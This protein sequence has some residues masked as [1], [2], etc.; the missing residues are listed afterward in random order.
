MWIFRWII[1]LLIVFV[2]VMFFAQNSNEVVT[3]NLMNK[4]PEMP[5][6]L[7]LF[8]AATIG[9]LI[10]TIVAIFNQIKLR[11]QISAMKREVRDV[12]E[13]LDRLRNFALEDEAED[14]GTGT[15]ESKS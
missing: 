1:L 7:S 9:F 4:H 12:R 10:A 8:L 6:S 11:M 14:D 15:E 2:M 3:I 13:E 5:L